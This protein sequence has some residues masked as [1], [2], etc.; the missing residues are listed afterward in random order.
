MAKINIT[1]Y[2]LDGSEM[3]I[4]VQAADEASA[5]TALLNELGDEII[6]GSPFAIWRETT[7][8]AVAAGKCKG[9]KGKI[10][11]SPRPTGVSLYDDEDEDEEEEEATSSTFPDIGRPVVKLPADDGAMED[12]FSRI[13]DDLGIR[14]KRMLS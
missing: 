6:A 13:S 3:E 11:G 8:R 4:V 9:G 14:I 5:L 2:V 12:L 1:F 7:P 10:L